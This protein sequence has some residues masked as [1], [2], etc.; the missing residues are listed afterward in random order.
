MHCLLTDETNTE[1]SERGKFFIYG[2]LFFPFAKFDDLDAGIA[3]IRKKAGYE[4]GDSFKFDTNFRPAHVSVEAS[5]QA[6]KEL[7]QLCLDSGCKFIALVIL[8]KIIDRQHPE[9]KY[10]WA[11]NEVIGRFNRFLAEEAKDTGIVLIDTL[12][13]KQQ[14][15]FL[16]EKFVKGLPL[17]T[18]GCTSLP[19]IRLYA[20][21]C[22]NASYLGSAID[23]VLGSFRYCI[24]APSNRQRAAEMMRRV[25]QLMWHSRAGNRIFVREKGLIL[26]PEKIIVDSYR[27]EYDQLREE[28][29]NLIRGE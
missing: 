11:A 17:H 27:K 8:H 26:R 18:G 1:P 14:W 20:S 22:L 25:L 10:L 21:T 12:P 16:T 7:V 2:G 9:H 24:N 29:T 13:L 19:R 28:I 15:Q 5:T 4:R 6:K 23:V 3:A